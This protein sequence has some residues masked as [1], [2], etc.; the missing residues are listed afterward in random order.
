[1]LHVWVLEN[2]KYAGVEICKYLDG[3]FKFNLL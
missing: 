3:S 2:P 1:M